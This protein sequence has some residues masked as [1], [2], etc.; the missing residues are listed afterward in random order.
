MNDHTDNVTDQQPSS[1]EKL[2]NITK[3][4]VIPPVPNYSLATV[5]PNCD[6]PVVRRAYKVHCERCGFMWDCSEL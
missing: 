6:A 4:P 2:R 3:M 5:C 1:A